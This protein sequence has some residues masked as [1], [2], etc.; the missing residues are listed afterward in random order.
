MKHI[1]QVVVAAVSAAMLLT[2][3]CSGGQDVKKDKDGNV[4]LTIQHITTSD[5]VPLYLGIE[6]GFFKEEGLNVEVKIAESGSAI[7]PSV[8]NGESPIGY[9]N[10]ISDLAAIDEG[11]DV[12]FVANCCGVGSDPK[13]DTSS[14]FVLKDSAIKGPEDL[15]GKRIAVNSVKN[16][17]DVTIPVALKNKGIDPKGI[18]W[19]PMNFSDMGAALERGDVDAI[20]QV[21]PFRTLATDAGYRPILSNFVEAIPD[22]T[23]GYYITSGKFAKS[24]PEVLQQFQR[25]MSKANEY[26]TEHPDEFRKLAVEKIKLD[27]AVAEKIN[28]APFKPGVDT[29]SLRTMGAYAVEFGIIKEEPNYDEHVVQP[30]S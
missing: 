1:R 4:Q 24:N 22:T 8:I 26:A 3:G 25:A 19:V 16:L 21:D 12:Q 9:A 14:I 20:W 6:K 29:E 23:V 17:G 15:P 18:E 7:I 27:P 13:K 11:L 28:V 30:K 5:S 10:V 2:A